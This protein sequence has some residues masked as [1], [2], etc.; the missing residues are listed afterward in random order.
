VSL[1]ASRHAAGLNP[2]NCRPQVLI[3]AISVNAIRGFSNRHGRCM[4]VAHVAEA[5]NWSPRERKRTDRRTAVPARPCRIAAS[6][7]GRPRSAVRL[8]ADTTG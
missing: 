5:S 1:A 2:T 3:A 8:K 7:T 4:P 6:D